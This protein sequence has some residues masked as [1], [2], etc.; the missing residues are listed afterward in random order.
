VN[1]DHSK[2]SGIC[3]HPENVCL[4]EKDSLRNIAPEKPVRIGVRNVNIIESDNDR[5]SREIYSPAIP[6]KL[7]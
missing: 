4:R 6:T 1:S 7:K 3:L 2:C 5:C